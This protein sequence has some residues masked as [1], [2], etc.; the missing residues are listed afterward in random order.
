[1]FE[2]P[3]VQAY[4]LGVVGFMVLG[5]VT[6][7]I[8]GATAAWKRFRK[9]PSRVPTPERGRPSADPASQLSR[10]GS[11]ARFVIGL[12]LVVAGWG[13]FV[14]LTS[15]LTE[16]QRR[17]WTSLLV[18][19]MVA[20][21]PHLAAGPIARRLPIW[22]IALLMTNLLV[23]GLAGQLLGVV[24]VVRLPASITLPTA[25]FPLPPAFLPNLLITAAGFAVIL[26]AVRVYVGRR[27]EL[28]LEMQ[29]E[30]KAIMRE[31]AELDRARTPAERARHA[32]EMA[33]SERSS[34][35]RMRIVIGLLVVLAVVAIYLAS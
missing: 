29:A 22:A 35:R 23:A 26:T 2:Q 33:A 7:F 24:E 10:V 31:E 4:I 16:E 25:I 12:V 9:T 27:F 1:M 14:A 32:A 19:P 11:F 21:V 15:P 20:I 30:I 3:L 6:L 5:Y 28:D 13:V 8:E 17:E 34:R 18:L